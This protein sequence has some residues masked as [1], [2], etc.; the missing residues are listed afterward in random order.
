MR[1]A[2]P[3]SL[4]QGN[5]AAALFDYPIGVRK[6]VKWNSNPSTFVGKTPRA[7]PQK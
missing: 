7:K 4:M 2:P 6:A 5:A 3:A 1:K